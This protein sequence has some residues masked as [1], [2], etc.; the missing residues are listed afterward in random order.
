[1]VP[2]AMEEGRR[3]RNHTLSVRC[4]DTSWEP[5]WFVRSLIPGL[6]GKVPYLG[7]FYSFFPLVW[8]VG[9]NWSPISFTYGY[10]LMAGKELWIY[11]MYS[12]N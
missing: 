8:E 11:G 12:N 5:L 3:P 10:N 6:W 1:M 7:T 4:L 9:G 2:F